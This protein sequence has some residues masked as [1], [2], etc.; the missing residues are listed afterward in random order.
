MLKG[1]IVHLRS[2]QPR[3]MQWEATG[4][5]GLQRGGVRE[6]ENNISIYCYLFQNKETMLKTTW[7]LAQGYITN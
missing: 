4:R 3:S 1:H 5:P 2:N 7:W 6:G